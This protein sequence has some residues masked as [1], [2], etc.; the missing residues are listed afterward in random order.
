MDHLHLRV[1]SLEKPASNK[2]ESFRSNCFCVE[3]TKILT[4]QNSITLLL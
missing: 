3:N 2:E 1:L 4:M